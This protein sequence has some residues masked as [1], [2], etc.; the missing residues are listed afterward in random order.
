LHTLNMHYH[1]Q[2][3]RRTTTNFNCKTCQFHKVGG[4]PYG[5]FGARDVDGAPW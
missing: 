3:L 5:H 4:R 2:Y 1:H